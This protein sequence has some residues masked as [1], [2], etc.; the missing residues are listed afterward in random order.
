MSTDKTTQAK[1]AAMEALQKI[2]T[3][4]CTA[5]THTYAV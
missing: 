2:N 5:G 4:A 3:G 1:Q